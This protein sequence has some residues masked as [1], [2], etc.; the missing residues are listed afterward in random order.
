MLDLLY[1]V[2]LKNQKTLKQKSLKNQLDLI[3]KQNVYV[4]LI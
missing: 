1:V 3:N 4:R 2:K